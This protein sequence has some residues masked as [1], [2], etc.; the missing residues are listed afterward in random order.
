[1]HG[2]KDDFVDGFVDDFVLLGY[3][4]C[5]ASQTFQNFGHGK[6]LFF[7]AGAGLH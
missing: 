6:W 2:V 3:G 1:V 4:S 5:S 7:V